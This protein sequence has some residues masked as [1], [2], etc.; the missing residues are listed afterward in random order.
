MEELSKKAIAKLR[1]EDYFE[2]QKE[3]KGS[4]TK[5]LKP[6]EDSGGTYQT[7]GSTSKAKSKDD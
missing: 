1:G 2:P 7:R 4:K 3:A 5:D 6:D